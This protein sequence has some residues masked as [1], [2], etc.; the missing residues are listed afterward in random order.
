[1]KK[2]LLILVVVITSIT[3]SAQ[4]SSK[5]GK[6]DMNQLK[7]ST[8]TQDSSANA[9]ILF[10][11]GE[12]EIIYN[13]SVGFQ[14]V[15]KRHRRIK[16]F[17]K[18]G[19]EWADVDIRL[20][21][22]SDGKE[23]ITG[24]KAATYNLEN[25][26]IATS[27]LDKKQII[28]ENVSENWEAVKFSFPNVQDGSIIEYR[29]TIISDFMFNLFDWQ[30]QYTIPSLYS[31]YKTNIPEFFTYHKETK[32]FENIY[33]KKSSTT[34]IVP[35]TDGN[36]TNNITFRLDEE[37]Y[38]AVSIPA[39]KQEQY[40]KAAQNY[41]SKIE[42][43]LAGEKFPGGRSHNYSKTWEDITK[44]ISDNSNF[45]LELNSDNFLKR[46]EIIQKAQTL[47]TTP[48]KISY[49][50]S[51]F[52]SKFKWDDKIN[53]YTSQSLKKTFNSLH[54]NSADLNLLLIAMLRNA[55]VEAYPVL[56]STTANGLLPRT[57]P[58][59]SSFNY[60][61][62]YAKLS[63][64]NYIL[65]DGTN[66]LLQIGMLPRY[67]YNDR[68][69][70]MYEKA[71]NWIPIQPV[72][73]YKKISNITISNLMDKSNCIL[74]QRSEGFSAFNLR[75]QFYKSK[76]TIE[77]IKD[78]ESNANF[79]INEYSFENLS[80]LNQAVMETYQIDLN[81]QIEKNTDIIFINPNI[82]ERISENPFKIEE[83]KF[84]VSYSY[85]I[86]INFVCNIEV[87]EGYEIDKIP[88]GIALKLPSDDASFAYN[89]FVN[90][91]YIMIRYSFNINKTT[92]IPSEYQN[93]KS[94]YNEVIN[95]QKEQIILKK[96][97]S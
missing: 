88:E 4:K 60:V 8:Y 69:R 43:E 66:P 80:D 96:K 29:Y 55:G 58:S 26:K 62:A 18:E 24:L 68:G 40:M 64:N 54:G 63:D 36:R 7:M 70:I 89:S 97:T 37:H 75:E 10:D 82:V 23:K 31:S 11:V 34:A 47:E 32:G 15:F 19:V 77:F 74:R 79:E 78:F 35:N 38:E 44:R 27:K 67:C 83:R 45:G 41:I 33:T 14:L 71:S 91:N 25:K 46:E 12:S 86:E 16:I 22:N 28:K 50:Y 30:F 65:L 56:L 51:Y 57:H 73:K 2:N 94:F 9:L 92:F 5:F 81:D 72:H 53:K 48:E 49:I 13:K 1:M 61:I 95:K 87:P 20:Y 90:G 93:L 76:D 42:F 39:F 85:P 17:N 52:Q 21:N 3:L 6:I 84:P 59:I